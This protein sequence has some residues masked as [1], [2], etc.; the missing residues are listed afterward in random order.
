MSIKKL[1]LVVAIGLF[2]FSTASFIFHGC[3]SPAYYLT[4]ESKSRAPLACAP[5]DGGRIDSDATP[6]A[7]PSAHEEL[8]VIA[9]PAD[10]S[11]P[12][13]DDPRAGALL[14]EQPGG[15]QVPLPLQHTDVRADVA[16]YIASVQVAQQ[17]HNPY[18]SKIEAVYVF[19]LPENAAVNEF[20][21]T[22]GDRRIRGIIRER[23]EAEQIYREARA[24]GH[25]ASLMTQERPNIFTQKVANIEPGKQIDVNITY[26]HTL[27]YHDGWFEFVFPMV[28]GPRFN[29]PHWNEGVGAV[30]HGSTGASGQPNVIPY[31][32]PGEVGGNGVSLAVRLD[33]G[34]G[35][36]ELA[37]RSH[38][39]VVDRPAPNKAVVRLD[40][41]DARPNKDFVLRWRVAGDA[42]KSALLTHRDSRGGFFSLMV[43]P[44]A[45]LARLPR[46]PMELIF[47]LDASG[48]MNGEPIA[49]A[50]DAISHALKSLTAEDTF[51]LI[52]FSM[53]ASSFGS[54]PV[55]A[56]SAN[57]KKALAY[58]R[59]LNGEGGTM[60]IEGIKAAL[61]FPHDPRRLRYVA[62]LTD[63]YIGNESEIL[64]E[65][66][67]SLG[68]SRIFSF[69]VGSSPNRFLI[70]RMAK[71]G[72]GA[73]AY[74][75][76]RD[77]GGAVMDAFLARAMQPALTDIGIDWG[78][79]AVTDVYPGEDGRIGDLYVGRP[80]I[81]TGRFSG[82]G[83]NG[84]IT[85]R[86]RAS[87]TATLASTR[88]DLT[89]IR[90]AADLSVAESRPALA[91]IWAR[92]KIAELSDR[93]CYQASGDLVGD[94][95]RVALDYNL[96][97]Q[98]TAF[99]AVDALSRTA[100]ATG[101]TVTV[102]VPVPEGVKYETTVTE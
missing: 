90:V 18:S 67:K 59:G 10:K 15:K 89:E 20:I 73:V 69:G 50:K 71:F 16:G 88:D 87:S 100:G 33:A 1:S 27:A 13:D 80:V 62:F 56:T 94:I 32:K 51:Q 7:L 60:M 93:S 9:K 91:A 83:S 4:P 36:E 99:V 54:E 48:S 61:N 21:M 86:G 97:S 19:P 46:R 96:L 42:V 92:H 8:W 37:C 98:F 35:I 5:R 79:L 55:A 34:V 30:G 31:L 70:D 58:L 95:R 23:A 43:V 6:G 17:Y 49:Q 63:G 85:L 24:Q 39:T 74:L 11:A 84:T 47:V 3:A 78:G 2:C 101:T 72:N 53:S 102:P 75:G 77:D 14:A 25:V 52:S 68:D 66:H 76:M 26:F 22:I 38:K 44:P 28:V 45:E 12:A 41:T 29:P 65:I 81:V 64:A 57:V 40:E 82:G